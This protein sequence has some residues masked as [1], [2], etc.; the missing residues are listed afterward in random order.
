MDKV[1]SLDELSLFSRHDRFV[2]FVATLIA[3]PLIVLLPLS[4][5]AKL[6]GLQRWEIEIERDKEWLATE[7]VRGWSASADRIQSITAEVRAGTY[8]AV[9]DDRRSR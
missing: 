8:S 4:F 7:K 1:N 3:A 5:A 9:G 2:L 6:C